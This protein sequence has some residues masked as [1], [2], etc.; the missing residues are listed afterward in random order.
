MLNLITQII[1]TFKSNP[2]LAGAFSLWGLTVIGIVARSVPAA[3]YHFVMSQA[4]T[5]LTIDSSGHWRVGL[6]FV[7]F[8]S[9]FAQRKG[10]NFS[11]ALSLDYQDDWDEEGTI[12]GQSREKVRK[13]SL[14]PGLGFHF[15][16][17]NGRLFWVTKTEQP[18]N[19]SSVPK[20]R[21]II[22]TF[23]RSREPIEKLVEEINPVL[24]NRKLQTMTINADGDWD[25]SSIITKRS[26]DSVILAPE[27]KTSILKLLDEFYSERDWY[28]DKGL[29]H[30]QTFIFHGKPGCGK[31]STV[32]ALASH[33]NRN[34]YTL[35]LNMVSD[36]SL[37]IYLSKVPPGSFVLIEDFDTFSVIKSREA[38]KDK[39]SLFEDDAGPLTLSG[40]LNALDG[41]AALDNIAI[42]L[43]TNHL[44][45]IDPAILREGR[46]DKI[47]ELKYLTTPE[48]Y[49][50]VKFAYGR[51]IHHYQF[52]D[53]PGCDLHGML[54]RH[55]RN[56]DGF[57]L[58]L[59][60]R[61]AVQ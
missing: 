61:F 49:E 36:R 19:G 16:V 53:I 3:I 29:A 48:I 7:S 57:M 11:R 12:A 56:Y 23:G 43:T 5:S 14:G 40:V 33:Y 37:P 17:F 42:F 15:F 2:L 22:S 27:T 13:L 39:K 59:K 38:K 9:W 45:Q 58:E 51:D 20:Y 31:T 35:N 50:Y 4:T 24:D 21:V 18:S 47:I 26:L 10:S 30:K 44:D 1:A 54:Q 41:I 6:A 60:E 28:L 55:K 34:V 8:G 32:K 25:I 52:V 46:T